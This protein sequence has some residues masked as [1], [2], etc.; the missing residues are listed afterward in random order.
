[1]LTSYSSTA[2]ITKANSFCRR[3]LQ[4]RKVTVLK[5]NAVDINDEGEMGRFIVGID[6][7]TRRVLTSV[8]VLFRVTA[9]YDTSDNVC[10]P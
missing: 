8:T 9:F 7:I 2:N 6:G 1:M 10:W 4:F 3:N 5:I